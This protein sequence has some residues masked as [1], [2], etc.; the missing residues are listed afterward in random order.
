MAPPSDEVSLTYPKKTAC[1]GYLQ[2]R[3]AAAVNY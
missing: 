3:L 2:E 1:H